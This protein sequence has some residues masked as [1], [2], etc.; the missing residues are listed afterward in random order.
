MCPCKPCCFQTLYVADGKTKEDIGWIREEF[1]V[2]IPTF[3]VR[4][5]HNTVL[6]YVHYEPCCTG[7]F[8]DCCLSG[9]CSCCAVQPWHMYHVAHGRHGR[10]SENPDGS[11]SHTLSVAS[12]S[13][14]LGDAHKFEVNFP[15]SGANTPRD[16]I[17]YIGAG[18][19]I[20]ELYYKPLC[21]EGCE[22]VCFS[23]ESCACCYEQVFRCRKC[24][25]GCFR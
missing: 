24:C 20:N 12:S 8:Y 22:C 13:S 5:E 9:I 3:S 16:K 2:T 19:L 15:T 14:L 11:F 4:D 18:W 21:A 7:L 1:W 17:L 23:G 10:A 25:P 6:V